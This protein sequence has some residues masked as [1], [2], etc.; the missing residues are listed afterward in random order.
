ME[1]RP[2]DRTDAAITALI[3]VA[4]LLY[5]LF[6]FD[7]WIGLL[8]EGYIHAI[9]DDVN[10]GAVLY[11][12]VYIDNPFPGSFHL[13]A[14]W[15]RL[16]GTSVLS[17]RVLA[18]V[19]FAVYAASFY[20]IVRASVPRAWALGFIVFL[21]AYRVWAFPHWQVYSYSLASA[22][23]ITAAAALL[24]SAVQH[25]SFAWIAAAGLVAG[26]SAV[27]K[28]DYGFAVTGG[29]GL[30]LLLLPL[31]RREAKGWTDWIARPAT[32]GA[33]VAVV[34]G[35]MVLWLASRGALDEFVQQAV[36]QPLRG[37]VGF[38]AYPRLPDPWPLWGQDA[39]LREQ[40]GHYFPSILV[41]LWWSSLS[42]GSLWRDTAFWDVTLKVVF[43]LP[44]L[45]Y[46]LAAALW[47]GRGAAD[48]ARGRPASLFV[49]PARVLLL[50]FAGGFLI[51][52]PPPRDWT[53]LMMIYPPQAA[54]GAVLLFDLDRRLGGTLRRVLRVGAAIVVAALFLSGFAMAIELRR[55]MSWPIDS[56]RAGVYADVQNGPI[57]DD[58]LAWAREESPSGEP[59]P[60]Y[61]LQPMLP[62]LAGREIAGGFHV[63]WPVQDPSRDVRIIDDLERRRPARVVYS[64]S[65]YQHLGRFQDNAPQLFDYLVDHYEIDRVFSRER[66]GP[67][68]VGLARRPDELRDATSLPY[69]G[70]RALDGAEPAR[71]PFADVLEVEVGTPLEPRSARLRLRV[72]PD[73][74][75][76]ALSYGLNPDRWMDLQDGPFTFT[77]E[78]VPLSGGVPHEVLRETI[79]P[80]GDVSARA[81]RAAEVD[82]APFARE[83]VEVV[84]R[85]AATERPKQPRDLAGWTVRVKPD[86]ASGSAQ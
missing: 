6:F 56:P 41:T 80:A 78:V 79:D 27:C 54:V 17:S 34:L 12:D 71:W 75:L 5:P 44:I 35:F 86:A 51:A 60:V 53:H 65:Q 42:V 11:R 76:L 50:G 45:A 83:P 7:R 18:L 46:A 55:Q 38:G 77:A 21:F 8:D 81:W 74:P 23:L 2:F 10:R 63:I 15:F 31:L 47:L 9:A 84:L 52:F 69:D 29:L 66:L 64:L 82:L 40:V 49:S 73:R 20:R 58:V 32:F 37:A 43:W 70:E 28:Q 19:G 61:P 59:L 25:G 68:L 62:F 14:L 30:A 16:F 72:D 1:P 26:L 48:A 85:V 33:G 36:V 3:G 39:H 13:L 22:T 57:L 24:V 4:A 67:L